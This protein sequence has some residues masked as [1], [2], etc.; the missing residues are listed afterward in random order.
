MLETVW[1]KGN[2]PSYTVVGMLIGVATKENIID[3]S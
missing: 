2:Q 3:V 1:S